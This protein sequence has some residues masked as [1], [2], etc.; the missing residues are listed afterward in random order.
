MIAT[1]EAA[2]LT[3]DEKKRQISDMLI[4]EGSDAVA[5]G[6]NVNWRIGRA[7]V[8]YAETFAPDADERQRKAC[9]REYAISIGM[10]DNTSRIHEFHAVAAFFPED[11]QS[12][13]HDVTWSRFRECQRNCRDLSH[14]SQILHQFGDA[15][16]AKV[17]EAI[18]GKVT[19][20]ATTVTFEAT[21]L[22][23]IECDITLRMIEANLFVETLSAHPGATVTVVVT[24]P[25]TEAKP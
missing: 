7:A 23:G 11:T 18:L 12:H 22:R 14:A 9:L 10:I 15:P 4:Q 17:R 16:V 3:V 25:A 19:P 6:Q 8:E 5:T 24:Y 21:Y 1:I 2:P 13:F 20:K